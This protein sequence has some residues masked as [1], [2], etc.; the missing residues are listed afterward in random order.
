MRHAPAGPVFVARCATLVL[1]LAVALVSVAEARAPIRKNF[2]SAYPTAV[3]SRLDNLP[4]H[5]THCGVCHYD[6]NGG[7]TRNP[8][9][10]AVGGTAMAAA[11][12]LGLGGLD[13]DGDGY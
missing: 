7:G 12:I 6:F 8:Y 11:A 1:S 5:T 10:V 9:G 3:G 2:F 4:S 13:S